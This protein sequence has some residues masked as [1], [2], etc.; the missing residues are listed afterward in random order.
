MPAPVVDLFSTLSTI[1]RG[2]RGIKN[3]DPGDLLCWSPEMKP[4]VTIT[5]KIEIWA[6]ESNGDLLLD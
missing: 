1:E 6:L 5:D 3:S 2:E 4:T